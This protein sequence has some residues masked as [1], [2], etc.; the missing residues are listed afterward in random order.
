MKELFLFFYRH[1]AYG[2]ART[3]RSTAI[4]YYDLT[5]VLHGELHYMLN[6]VPTVVKEGDA[7]LIKSGTLREREASHDKV[8]YVSFNFHTATPPVL[9]E[10]INDAV[11]G[12]I[13]LIITACD[14]IIRRHQTHY[15]QTMSYLLAAI[16]TTM[17][18]RYQNRNISTLT[19]KI[20][21]YLNKNLA[22]KITLADIGKLT[23]FSPV[24]CDTVFKKDMGAS[25][26]EYLLEQRVAEAKKLLIEGVFSPSEIA[27]MTGFEDSNYFSRVFKKRTGYTPTQYKKLQNSE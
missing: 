18:D 21:K 25:I 11:H 27:A 20:L 26:I 6:G 8:D 4:A 9:P 24:Y 12:D 22:R 1:N 15:E 3:I 16:L 5:I 2:N 13:K 19:S 10:I 23:F 14:D 7:I 17:E